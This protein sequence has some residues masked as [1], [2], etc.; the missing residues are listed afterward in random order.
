M[1][2]FRTVVCALV[3]A[4]SFSSLHAAK[5]VIS[6]FVKILGPGEVFS[7]IPEATGKTDAA[8][9]VD[10]PVVFTAEYAKDFEVDGDL[11]LF[12]VGHPGD[13][14]GHGQNVGGQ[15]LGSDDGIDQAGFTTLEFADHGHPVQ[16]S[17][18][19]V[20][21]LADLLPKR[22]GGVVLA[23]DAFH[24]KQLLMQ[25]IFIHSEA[26]LSAGMIE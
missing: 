25:H 17:L 22:L 23:Q 3:A 4:C 5:S 10:A 19:P 14:G 26:L 8:R 6:D 24:G 9:L 1:V 15:H 16:L 7:P 11:A 20:Y 13:G 12:T 2:D 18:D 21:G